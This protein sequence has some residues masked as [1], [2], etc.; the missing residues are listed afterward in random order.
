MVFNITA[1]D[2]LPLESLEKAGIGLCSSFGVVYVVAALYIY[3]KDVTGPRTGTGSGTGPANDETV[4]LLTEEEMQRRQLSSLLEQRQR[5][6]L[7][8]SSPRTMPKTFR[9]DG[10]EQLHVGSREW[11][12]Y[13]R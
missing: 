3:A 8:S 5:D 12:R 6:G 10:P 9:V 11:D 4:E 1:R 13:K 7:Q 2:L